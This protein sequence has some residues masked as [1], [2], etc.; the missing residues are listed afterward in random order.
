MNSLRIVVDVGT[1]RG[2]LSTGWSRAAGDGSELGLAGRHIGLYLRGGEHDVA[3]LG[4]EVGR[5]PCEREPF[6]DQKQI[7]QRLYLVQIS[8][9]R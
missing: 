5:Q 9:S 4:R 1:E 2:P 3:V 7:Y 8:R 6:T